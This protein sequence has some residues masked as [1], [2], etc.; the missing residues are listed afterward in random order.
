M[1]SGE[2]VILP[3]RG[4]PQRFLPTSLNPR[5]AVQARFTAISLHG[6]S[7]KR[8]SRILGDS[9]GSS[10]VYRPAGAG[11]V[12]ATLRVY[13]ERYES[14]EGD[15]GEDAQK[16]LADLIALSRSL[17]EIE[18]RTGRKAPSVV[19]TADRVRREGLLQLQGR[20]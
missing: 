10:I 4:H 16:M 19:T 8:W 1:G 9:G 14:P 13:I 12:G 2:I 3:D 5:L 6:G 18:P 7:R 17:A 20:G 15:L 11:A